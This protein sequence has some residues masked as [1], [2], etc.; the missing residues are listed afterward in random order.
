MY[1][2]FHKDEYLVSAKKYPYVSN[3][4]IKQHNSI[5]REVEKLANEGYRLQS[6]AE[7]QNNITATILGLIP[8]GVFYF[9]FL[10]NFWQDEIF[11]G[12]IT[13]LFPAFPIYGIAYGVVNAI[14]EST[15]N[16]SHDLK[17][18]ERSI[19]EKKIYL[20][21]ELQMFE[22]LKKKQAEHWLSMSGHQFEKG[23]ARLYEAYG[24]DVQLTKGSGD[25]GIDIFLENDGQ[26]YGVQCKN[27]HGAIGP[28][29]IR[30]LYGAMSHEGLDGGIFIA[31]S[32]YTKGAKEFADNKAI[33]LLDINDVLRMHAATLAE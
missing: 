33:R 9:Y 21:N 29:A 27:H 22:E 11:I 16:N 25:G 12:M 18:L 20:D 30:D 2:Y 1:F 17:D 26:R 6:E 32:G 5:V 3:E 4:R 8:A 28:A 13:L 14:L 7:K 23:V 10:I 15:T 31:S 19:E 24:Y